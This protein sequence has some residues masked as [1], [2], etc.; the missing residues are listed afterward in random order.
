M[1][2]TNGA[3]ASWSKTSISDLH[4]NRYTVDSE[5]MCLV[6]L[7]IIGLEGKLMLEKEDLPIS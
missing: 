4:M 6:N 3:N 2:L 5:I 7:Q 1:G